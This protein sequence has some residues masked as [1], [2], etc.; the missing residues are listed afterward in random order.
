MRGWLAITRFKPTLFIRSF[1][2]PFIWCPFE[3][4]TS[5]FLFAYILLAYSCSVCL[6]YECI[7][8]VVLVEILTF[9]SFLKIGFV[10]SLGSI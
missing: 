2:L 1:L 4:G 3:G 7:H 8:W 9:W 5:P 10:H 6:L